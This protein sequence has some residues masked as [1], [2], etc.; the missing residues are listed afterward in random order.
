MLSVSFL[1]ATLS[2]AMPSV[3]ILS[4]ILLSVVLLLLY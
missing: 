2:V 3:N 1:F 4:A